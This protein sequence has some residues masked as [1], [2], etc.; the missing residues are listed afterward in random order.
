MSTLTGR[1]PPTGSTSPSCKARSSLTCAFGG[2]S[3]ISSR[4][5]VPPCA[6]TNLP[7]CFS[8]AP[9]NAPFSC[10]NRI[11]S[12]RFSGSAPQLTVTKARPR[13]SDV[14]W[15]ARATNSLPTPDSPS[16]RTGMFDFAA[17]SPS[18]TTRIISSLLES[19]SFRCSAPEARL[20]IRRISSSSASKRSAFLID[21]CSRS[22]PTGLTTKSIAPARIAEITASIEPCAVW[23][24]T[25]IAR[26]LSRMRVKT[27]MPS[28]SGMTRS[29]IIRSTCGSR[30]MRARAC[31]P[32]SAV[33]AA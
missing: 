1:L 10:P 33:S 19:R 25:G 3:P 30:S 6:S 4:N 18:R 23:T 15:T 5:S 20:F 7:A 12:T 11:D 16:S 9:V 22:A 31:S 8:V 26:P 24:M 32:L 27:P 28:R 29:R 14:P 21:T 13:R 17:R 2:S